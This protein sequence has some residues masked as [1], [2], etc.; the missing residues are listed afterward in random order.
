MI[1]LFTNP[2]VFKNWQ[3]QLT[4]VFITDSTC[5]E[6]SDEHLKV[7]YIYFNS[8]SAAVGKGTGLAL[9]CEKFQQIH[10]PKCFY[11]LQKKNSRV[12]CSCKKAFIK[13]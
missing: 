11:S 13:I 9:F 3:E 1:L 4:K 7:H 12:T 8:E 10:A 6:K 2:L 5:A